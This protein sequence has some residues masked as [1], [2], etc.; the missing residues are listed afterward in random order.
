MDERR[1]TGAPS[2]AGLLERSDVMNELDGTLAGIATAGGQ[3]VLV[4]GEAGIGKSAL[5][6]RFAERHGAD[7]WCLLGVCDPL[8]PRALGPLHDIARRSGGRLAMGGS[9]EAVF[10]AFLDELEQGPQR[11]AVVVVEDAHWADEATLDLLVFVGRRLERLPALLLV[12]YRDDELGADHPL[13]A[14]VA[15]LPRGR[16]RRARLRPLSEGAVAELARRAGRPA[17]GVHALTGG[18]P[19]LVTEVLATGEPGVPGTGPGPGP[20]APGQAATGC[21]GGRAAGCGGPHPD[22]AVAAGGGVA[23]GAGHGGGVRL[24]R[25]ADRG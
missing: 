10:A 2:A 25:A 8:T 21:A 1:P 3:A 14:A 17:A 13:R 9:R 6:R 12:T 5:V 7:A 15:G 18:N 23:A 4:S 11:R 22:G 24:G 20:G 16:V 19:L